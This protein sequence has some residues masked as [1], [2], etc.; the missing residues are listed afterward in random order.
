M[1]GAAAVVGGEATTFPA[2]L[3]RLS[4]EERLAFMFAGRG[5]IERRRGLE[6]AVGGVAVVVVKI[7][8]MCECDVWRGLDLRKEPKMV[9]LADGG[10]SAES[11]PIPAIP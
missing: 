11:L 3:R 10:A 1:G 7:G 2:D 8:S 4:I 9:V 6:A 5:A